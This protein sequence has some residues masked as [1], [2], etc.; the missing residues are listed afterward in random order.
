MRDRLSR[1]EQAAGAGA[2]LD[3]RVSTGT[4]AECECLSLR[5]CAQR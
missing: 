2:L 5:W 3:G 1:R 4:L